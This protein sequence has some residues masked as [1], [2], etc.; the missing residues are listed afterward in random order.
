MAGA[1]LTPR[2]SPTYSVLSAAKPRITVR[3]DAD[4]ALDL[5][6]G[7]PMPGHDCFVHFLRRVPTVGTDT[8]YIL[9]RHLT[10]QTA[11]PRGRHR[12]QLEQAEQVCNDGHSVLF[13]TVMGVCE[14]CY[15]GTPLVNKGAE[16]TEQSGVHRQFSVRV[17]QD[18]R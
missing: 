14:K 18:P 4:D 8:V 15:R 12:R 10:R 3:V 16:W 13:L 1:H 5:G 17:D 2:E 11:I 9:E 7:S 6:I